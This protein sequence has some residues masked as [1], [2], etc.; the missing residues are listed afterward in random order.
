ML[1]YV[2]GGGKFAN[3]YYKHDNY[4]TRNFRKINVIDWGKDGN[5]INNWHSFGYPDN[6][7]SYINVFLYK[8]PIGW[9]S[10]TGERIYEGKLYMRIQGNYYYYQSG[11]KYSY[12]TENYSSQPI[13][14]TMGEYEYTYKVKKLLMLQKQTILTAVLL[15]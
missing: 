14:S 4:P 11:D 7:P 15:Y 12:G 6:Q 13:Y 5:N 2:L 9:E 3:G 8:K 10:S 1:I